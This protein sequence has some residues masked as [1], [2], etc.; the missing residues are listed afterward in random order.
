MV[1][2]KA[3]DRKSGSRSPVKRDGAAV[4]PYSSPR[5]K[6]ANNR[7]HRRRGER[8]VQHRTRPG[9]F[10]QLRSAILISLVV[11][12]ASAVAFYWVAFRYDTLMSTTSV[13]HTLLIT[14]YGILVLIYL[15]TRIILY[16]LYTPYPDN[17]FRPPITVVV[18]AYNEGPFI[19]RTLEG[20]A[21]AE[22]PES[23]RQIVVV[24]DGSEDDTGEAV[25]QFMKDNPGV[26][27]FVQF[28]ENQGK[29]T[30]MAEGVRRAKGEIVVF[31][32]SDTIV[33][34]SAL[35]YIVAPFEDARVGG[36]TG[37]VQVENRFKNLLTRML[38]VRYI[39]SFDFYRCTASTYGGVICLSGV[40]SAYRREILDRVI[41][42]WIEQ[43]FLGNICTYG[44][45]R[46]LTNYVLKQG[47]NTVYCRDSVA[48]TLA[49][50]TVS[51]L[52]KMLVR[53]NRSFVRESIILFKYLFDRKVIK[54]R[55]MLF[56]DSM[57]TCLMPFFMLSIVVTMYLRVI[58]EPIYV[59]M[60]VASITMMA[61]IYMMFY[62]RSEKDW[63]FIY[64]IIYA[65]FY[66]LILIWILPFATLTLRRTH[67]GTR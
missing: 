24:D 28:E 17:G 5:G 37:K 7:E 45:D 4:A 1:E 9:T 63:Q 40:I 42:G 64:G 54:T 51:R 66:V 58:Q 57:I 21:R 22:Y 65:F 27:E 32:D 19:K 29:R 44:D 2:E 15:P 46:S 52:F 62:V 47:Y 60:V 3:C 67:W 33:E 26:V 36:A 49:P 11:V 53:W 39:M 20:V 18:P 34:E 14:A 30:A 56:F 48:N 23:R 43:T 13:L 35:R 38:G 6:A 41:P 55:K 59:V 16:I 61:F 10:K 25:R 50:E 31:I 12:V 8:R